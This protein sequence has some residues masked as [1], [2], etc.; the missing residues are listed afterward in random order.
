ML[1]RLLFF[2][3]WISTQDVLKAQTAAESMQ[4]AEEQARAGN[5]SLALKTYQRVLFFGGDP[6]K[7][8]C[9]R[10]LATLFA[11]QGEF[12]RAA[13]YYDLLYQSAKTDSL[14]YEALFS[15]T[16][17][18]M[19]QNQ[20]KKALLELLSLPQNLPEPWM[21]RKRL[22]LGAAHFG[23]RE[24][25]LARQDLLPLFAMEDHSGKTKFEQL[26]RQA[27]RI[28]RKSAKK[29]RNL[30][31]VL[32]GAGQFYAGDYKNGINSLLV[33]ALLGYWLVSTGISFTFL[34][35]AATVSPW[36]FRYYA[37]GMRRAGEILEKKKEEGLRKVFGKVLM[38]LEK[39]KM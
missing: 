34:D 11:A 17:L 28:S 25:D 26:M 2:L 35:A 22:Y 31:M 13:F 8:V 4:F 16:G 24:F 6:Y 7:E 27:E 20:Y 37:G 33:N 3:C 9:Q 15:K 23:I 18:L 39:P 21:S 19:L 14:R 12:D 5:Q 30:S 32:P 1:P 29:A 10:E 38:E 36:L